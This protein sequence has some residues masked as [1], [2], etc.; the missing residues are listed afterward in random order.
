MA[1]RSSEGLPSAAGADQ[2]NPTS[3]VRRDRLTWK[4]IAFLVIA[5]WIAV[6]TLV[7]FFRGFDDANLRGS[8][9][10]AAAQYQHFL[11]RGWYP[12]EVDPF[13]SQSRPTQSWIGIN[14]SRGTSSIIGVATT[15]Q[16]V[17]LRLSPVA[18]ANGAVQRLRITQGT[19]SLGQFAMPDGWAW[20]SIRLKSHTDV[21]TLH[22]S[23]TLS[24]PVGGLGLQGARVIAVALAGVQGKD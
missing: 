5:V 22:Y 6:S 1:S 12:L 11:G 18:C 8:A 19:K 17:R 3:S 13:A 7:I 2:E 24:Q 10:Q 23:C 20:Y 14:Y 9:E 21:V 16:Q 4:R 15:W